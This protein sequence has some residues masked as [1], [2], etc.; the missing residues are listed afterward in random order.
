MYDIPYANLPIDYFE[1]DL[2]QTKNILDV[3]T[4]NLSKWYRAPHASI[5]NEM[6]DVIK[7]HN[8]THVIG[9]VFANDTSI[10]DPKWIANLILKTVQP[11]S[12]VILHMPERGVR[13]WT[14][15]A[16]ELVLK[17]LTEKN[18]NMLNLTG[19]EIKSKL[20][21]LN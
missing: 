6:H 14:Y 2:I 15:E 3:Y 19:L 11:G 20:I 8:L 7:K 16:L 12:I 4:N 21:D 17:G 9:D 5:T 13:E 10:P 18:L 1:K